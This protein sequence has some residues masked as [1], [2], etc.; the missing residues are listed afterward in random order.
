MSHQVTL[1]PSGK[2]FPVHQAESVLDA[3][4]RAGLNMNYSCA[5]GGC[6]DC[7]AKVVRGDYEQ[8]QF[9][10]F[11]L[12]QADTDQNVVLMCCISANSDLIIEAS[13]A[14][15]AADIAQQEVMVKVAKIEAVDEQHCVL[16]LRTPRSKTLRFLAG[17]F[18]DLSLGGLPPRSCAIASC[19]CNGMVLQF[20]VHRDGSEFSDYVFE[21]LKPSESLKVQGPMGEFALDEE[22]RRPMVMVAQDTGFGALKSLIEHAIAL[23]MEQS[24][25]LFWVVSPGQS[26]Y[27]ENYCRSWQHA[28]D[29]FMYFTMELTNGGDDV[30]AKV[31][32]DMVARS[33]IETEI[34]LYVAGPEPLIRQTTTA[35]KARGTPP[36]RVMLTSVY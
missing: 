36:S 12:S 33:P 17:Q 9:H 28:L 16:H 13:L 18:A 14:K 10:D 4:L 3:A 5:S 19:P 8:I 7:K 35:F 24:L 23:E 6:G 30:Y 22:S 20:H 29:N 32:Q 11:A 1:L 26:P 21:K 25:T 15:N 34:D 2:V 31:I 27:L